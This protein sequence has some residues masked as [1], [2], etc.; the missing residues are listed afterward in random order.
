VLLLSIALALRA[1]GLGRVE[2]LLSRI[3]EG[4]RATRTEPLPAL[5]RRV[6]EAAARAPVPVRCLAR[7]VCLR[8]LL[9]CHGFDA[10]LRIGTAL[11][12]GAFRAH[13]WVDIDGLVVGD[14]AENVTRYTAFQHEFGTPAGRR[15]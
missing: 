13:A 2:T 1:L 12:R 5:V 7:A 3:P 10:R 9:G 15:S 14:D 4:R 6:E 11:D 8:W